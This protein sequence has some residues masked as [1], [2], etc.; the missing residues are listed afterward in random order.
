MNAGVVEEY[1]RGYYPRHFGPRLLVATP[2]STAMRLFVDY[3]VV[4]KKTQN[5]SGGISN[6]EKTLE[7]IANCRLMTKIDKGRCFC[8]I[9]L[10][11]AAQ[12]LLALVTPKSRVFR[13]KVMTIGVVNAPAL[14]Q[15]L[16]NKM[17]NIL[18]CRPLVQELVSR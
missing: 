8:Q 13:W 18:R 12:E 17:L 5:H 10:T 11:R 14:F 15:E 4:N 1:K 9:D 6:L 2:C 3:R 7:R 16:M